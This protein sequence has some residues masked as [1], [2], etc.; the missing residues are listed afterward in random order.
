MLKSLVQWFSHG[1]K[2]DSIFSDKIMIKNPSI[3]VKKIKSVK[4]LLTKVNATQIPT[5]YSVD[6]K[7]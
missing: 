4:E 1:F 5:L 3:L 6:T 7:L 2:I